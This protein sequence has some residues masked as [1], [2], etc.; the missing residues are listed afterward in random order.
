MDCLASLLSFVPSK[1]LEGKRIGLFSYGSGL[2]ASFMSFRVSGNVDTIA[3]VLDIPA[4]LEARRAVPP[5][6]YDEMCN[7]RKQAHLQKDYTPKG[8]TSTINP[9]AYYLTTAL[10]GE[11]ILEGGYDICARYVHLCPVYPHC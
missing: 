2:A 5:A 7:L 4:R 6:T 8:E 3:K 9:G 11:A 10:L 1:D